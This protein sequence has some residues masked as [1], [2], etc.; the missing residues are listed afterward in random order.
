MAERWRAGMAGVV[1]GMLVERRW[2]TGEP[3]SFEEYLDTATTTIAVRP[4]TVTACVLA[5]EPGAVAAFDALD[6][7]IATV[8]R[9]FRLA[10]DLRSEARERDEGTVN[11]VTPPIATEYEASVARYWDTKRDDQINLLLGADDGL[12]H[13]HYGVGDYDHAILDLPD[14]EREPAILRELHRMENRQTELI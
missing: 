3:P 14:A 6:P 5:G 9:C 11:A 13:H 2:S 7:L 12:I 4:Y 8:A 1:R 10:N